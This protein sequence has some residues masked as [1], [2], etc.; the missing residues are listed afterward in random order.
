MTPTTTTTTTTTTTITTITTT[1]PTF[2]MFVVVDGI[3]KTLNVD[4]F[5]IGSKLVFIVAPAATTTDNIQLFTYIEAGD[6]INPQVSAG[7][8]EEM[9]PLDPRENLVLIADSTDVS[10]TAAGTGY[11]ATEVLTVT[12]GTL[13]SGGSA[14]TIT[15]DTVSIENAIG[16]LKED[17]QIMVK[18]EKE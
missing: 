8:T 15:V 16:R 13:A 3:E 11:A 7:I 6:L 12:G 10:L 14:M 18:N 1:T 5:F 9:V 17:A 2:F 4:Y